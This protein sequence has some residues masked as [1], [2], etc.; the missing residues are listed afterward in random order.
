LAAEITHSGFAVYFV[1][2]SFALSCWLTPTGIQ[3]FF[4]RSLVHPGKP[5]SAPGKWTGKKKWYWCGRR[6]L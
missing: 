1:S 3:C 4:G 5:E 6:C 2:K